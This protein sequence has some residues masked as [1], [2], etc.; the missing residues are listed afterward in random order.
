[1]AEIKKQFL[2]PPVSI[3]GAGP[4]CRFN[5]NDHVPQKGRPPSRK[6]LT[7]LLTKGQDVRRTV[8]TQEPAVK[9]ADFGI[10]HQK[11]GKARPLPPEPCQNFPNPPKEPGA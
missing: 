4:P 11:K 3:F 6:G 10:V 8:L 9:T 1:M 5:R 7:F 2:V